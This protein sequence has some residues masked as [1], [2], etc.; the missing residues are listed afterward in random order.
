M[1][2]FYGGYWRPT[3]AAFYLYEHVVDLDESTI[4]DDTK[5]TEIMEHLMEVFVTTVCIAE[6]YSVSLSRAYRDLKYRIELGELAS[7]LRNEREIGF[8]ELVR[9]T[10]RQTSEIARI[11]TFYELDRLPID[12]IDLP[13]LR[14][15]IPRLHAVIVESFAASGVSFRDALGAK[16]QSAADSHRFERHFDPGT[17]PCIDQFK[18]VQENSACPFALAARLWGAPPYESTQSVRENLIS[19]LPI[20]TSFTRVAQKEV[21]DGFLYAFPVNTFGSDIPN[22]C[23]LMKTFVAFLM[24]NDPANPRVFSRDDVL[25]PEWHFSYGGEDYFI[26]VH[27]PHYSHDHTRYTHGVRDWIFVMLQPNSSF[28][29][30]ITRERFEEARQNVRVAFDNIYQGYDHQPLEAHRF[31]LPDSYSDPPVAWYDAVGFEEHIGGYF[32]PPD[33]E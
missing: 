12:A 6:Q 31:V 15:A 18:R 7:A 4:T 19:S 17:A 32:M 14:E 9:E 30:R 33:V 28:H 23:K 13:S 8:D 29:S 25:S 21:L 11:V 27:S 16:L 22:L 3:S 26:N 20:L 10:K 1:V 2:Q 5:R 24:A